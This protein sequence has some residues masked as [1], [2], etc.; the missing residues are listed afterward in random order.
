LNAPPYLR[1]S[2]APGLDGPPALYPP[3][4][5][6]RFP[7][8]RI[9]R[10]ELNE[11]AGAVRLDDHV[12]GVSAESFS[13]AQSLHL[14]DQAGEFAGTAHIPLLPVLDDGGE[15]PVPACRPPER[16][17][18]AAAGDT[19]ADHPDRRP[20][21]LRGRIGDEVVGGLGGKVLAPVGERLS[22][23][24][25]V[26]DGQAL[27]E[28]LSSRA[29]PLVWFESG[30]P[31][32]HGAEPDA[33]D[34]PAAAQPV[35][36]RDRRREIPGPPARGRGQQR[37]EPDPFGHHSGRAE[38]DPGVHPP[39]RFPREHTVPAVPLA[40]RGEL[41]ELAC[42]GVRHHESEAH[43]ATVTQ[44]TD[45]PGGDKPVAAHESR[46]EAARVDLGSAAQQW[47]THGLLI[48]PAF[49][50][51]T[52]LKPALDE[53]PAMYPTAEGFHDGTD[54]RRD[55]FTVD[56]WAGIDSFPFLSTE[57][58]LLA[59]SNR[60]V[61]LAETLLE[62]ADL[63]ISS[64]EAWAKYTGAAEYD[65]SLHRD[66][67]NQTLMVPTDDLRFRQLEMFVYLVDVPEELGPPSMLSR[68]R[69]TGLPLKP[70]WY[71]RESGADPEGGWVATTGSP[72]LFDAEV[73]AAGPAGTVVAWQTGTFHRGTALTLP[74]GARYTIH[75]V[76]RPSSVE[77]GQRMAWPHRSHEPGW[78]RFAHRA[79]PRQLALF[80]FPP[81]G[82]PY[83][84]E[85]T[86]AGT[87]QRYPGLNLTPWRQAL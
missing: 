5:S 50:P 26:V 59:V 33:H 28:L 23:H 76:Y 87:A 42:V 69:T 21:P 38:R 49:V 52:E 39:D 56:E 17:L 61:D 62:E 57:L 86:L 72:D 4:G 22:A 66:Y 51:A 64:A 31:L 83:W 18:R 80:G 55:R 82:H 79:S 37:A 2:G 71:P 29:A 84:T 6:R 85:A 8:R 78:Y 47:Q 34:G 35:H 81:P 12:E 46:R 9:R 67:L 60:V 3:R 32:L 11:L 1:E 24:Q 14:V 68:T 74:R 16:G 44:P 48:L 30:P 10:V 54:E 45:I 7:R 53:L 27:V 19:R 25:P 63:R 13:R 73:R 36:R 75:L 20:R 43:E 65:Q 15:Q 58:S 70:N 77:W 41:G 40:E